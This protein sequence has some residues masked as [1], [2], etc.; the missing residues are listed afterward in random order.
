MICCLC[1]FVLGW[2]GLVYFVGFDFVD[3]CFAGLLV[4]WFGICCLALLL[5]FVW[6]LCWFGVFFGVCVI[7]V[8]VW[9]YCCFGCCFGVI[10]AGFGAFCVW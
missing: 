3:V 2:F 9:C 5:G 10:F 4:C 7:V 6:L 8:L 1:L